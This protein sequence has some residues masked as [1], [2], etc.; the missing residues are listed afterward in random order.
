MAQRA[1]DAGRGARRRIEDILARLAQTQD[2]HVLLYEAVDAAIDITG[3]DMGN[4]QLLEPGNGSLKD[5]GKPGVFH[6]V[7]GIF[8]DGWRPHEFRLRRRAEQPDA[9][10]R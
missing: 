1:A 10:H 6:P 7:S 3:A 4:I 2:V 8:R 5:C 9:D